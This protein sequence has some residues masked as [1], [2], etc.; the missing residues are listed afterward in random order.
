[1]PFASQEEYISALK[2]HDWWYDRSDD[3]SVYRSGSRERADLVAAAEK[4]DPDYAIWNAYAPEYFQHK[5]LKG[6]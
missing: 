3:P 4:I 5:P 1:M 2:S 6:N